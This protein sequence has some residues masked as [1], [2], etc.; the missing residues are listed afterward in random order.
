MK[1]CTCYGDDN[2][3]MKP[4]PCRIHG[5]ELRVYDVCASGCASKFQEYVNHNVD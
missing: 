1:V 5:I 3:R 4:I 2:V